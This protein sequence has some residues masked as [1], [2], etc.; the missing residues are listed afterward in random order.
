MSDEPSPTLDTLASEITK[1]SGTLTSY[2][3]AN[4]VPAPSFEVDSPEGYGDRDLP[5]DV[6]RAR[7]LLL[8][9]LV[10]MWFLA[11]GPSGG[12]LTFAHTVC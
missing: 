10:D 1:L 4:G 9:A 11:W 5:P 2:M 12:V 7:Q 6:F 8:D 3:R